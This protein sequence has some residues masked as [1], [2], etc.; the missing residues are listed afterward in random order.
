M[1]NCGM[2]VY[3]YMHIGNARAYVFADVLRRY[4]EYRG[5]KVKQVINITDVGHLTQDDIEAGED[6]IQAAAKKKKVTPTQIARF[7]E[8]DFLKQLKISKAEI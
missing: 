4:L 2:T 6:K 1:Y 8:K 7:Y 5:Y 3:G